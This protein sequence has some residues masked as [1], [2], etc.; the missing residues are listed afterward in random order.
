MIYM[1]IQ[2]SIGNHGGGRHQ[3]NITYADVQYNWQVRR[4]L[5]TFS[6]LRQPLDQSAVFELQLHHLQHFARH[7]EDLDSIASP[8]SLP[9]RPARRMVV[10]H[11]IPYCPKYNL[12]YNLLLH[13]NLSMFSTEQDLEPYRPRTLP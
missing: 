9:I 3:W 8:P 11:A 10:A 13:P 6:I 1:A 5:E 12:L 4:E 7:D 2:L